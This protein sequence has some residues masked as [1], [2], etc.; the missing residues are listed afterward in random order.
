VRGSGLRGVWCE[1]ADMRRPI[2]IMAGSS[3]QGRFAGLLSSPSEQALAA[4]K[5]LKAPDWLPE[6][7]HPA[8]GRKEVKPWPICD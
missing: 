4:R 8:I 1:P 7:P 3:A 5:S 2:P 6:R